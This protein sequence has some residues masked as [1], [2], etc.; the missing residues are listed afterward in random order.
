MFQPILGSIGRTI[1]YVLVWIVYAVFHVF[2]LL[3]LTDLPVG[4]IILDGFVHAV[5]LG[6]EGMLLLIVIKYGNYSVLNRFQQLINFTALGLLSIG[7]WLGSGYGL[8]YW[9]FDTGVSLKMLPELPALGLIG[10]L[11]YLLMIQH[12]RCVLGQTGL[13]ENNGNE[14]DA[15]PQTRLPQ[16]TTE[17]EI[18]ERIAVKSGSK[19]HVVLVPEIIYL[20]ADGDYVQ[21][22]T[23]NGKFLKEQTMKYFEEHLP[24][25]QFVRVHR[26]VI[27][28]VE[29]IS[30]IE[31]YEKQSQQ[32]TLK[33][34]QQ[35]KT[36]PAGY[37]AL[38][39]ALNL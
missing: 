34:G 29:M 3:P 5:V 25:N 36:S 19:I 12:F 30:R 32:L 22:F 16:K 38:R 6:F 1:R 39:A 14:P 28:N 33:N 15:Q 17:T 2:V 23:T 37:K 24:E 26:S 11:V 20:Q 10:L 27:V 7:L 13:N 8:M 4:I 18:L 35:I 9:F 21:L 31:L